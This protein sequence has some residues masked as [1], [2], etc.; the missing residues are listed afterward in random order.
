MTLIKNFINAAVVCL[1]I[2]SLTAVGFSQKTDDKTEVKRVMWEAV[3][4]SERDLFLGP[5]G[6]EMLPDLKK[7]QYIGR[8]EGGTSIKYRFKDSTGR[9]WVA[10]IGRETQTETAAVR[11]LWGLGYKTEINYLVKSLSIPTVGNY[12]NVRFEARPEN[13][14]RLNNWSW[15][16]NPFVGT[17]EFEGLKLMMA[18]FNNWDI[19]DENTAIIKD[20]DV[21]HY[22]ISDLGATF[23][24]LPETGGGK[25]GRSVNKPDQYAQSKFIKQVRDGVIELDYR[26]KPDNV[27][28]TFK[29][30]HGRWLADLLL[31]LSNKQIEDA[32]RA[33]NYDNEE[34]KL[35]AQ[36]FKARITELDEATKPAA[37]TAINE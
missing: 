26:G 13:V 35:L 21:H 7:V 16:D 9:E 34:I 10:K 14:K 3:N 32:F 27:I 31:Q 5:G 29:V 22:I 33:A 1:L 24:K 8:Q 23:G 17:N 36:A 19:K 37:T 12:K 6:Q 20:G 4:I 25:S 18:M 11:L 30:E 15:S 2:G 28:G